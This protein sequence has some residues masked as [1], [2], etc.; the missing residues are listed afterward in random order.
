M[1][2]KV[3]LFL[4]MGFAGIFALFSKNIMDTSTRTVDNYAFTLV[5]RKHIT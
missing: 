1:G 2:G 5:N 3:S 4:V